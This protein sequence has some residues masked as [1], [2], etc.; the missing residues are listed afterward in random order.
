MQRDQTEKTEKNGQTY[1][2][3]LNPSTLISLSWKPA[4]SSFETPSLL[5]SLDYTILRRLY[6][7]QDRHK[8]YAL[9]REFKL[10]SILHLQ[11]VF[12]HSNLA[13]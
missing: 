12:H 7:K 9:I 3:R 1:L 10:S 13:H 8:T 5:Y 11:T 2:E 6:N 4:T